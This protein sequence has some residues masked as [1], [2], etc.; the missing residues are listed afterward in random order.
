[1]PVIQQPL[2][3]VTAP[4]GKSLHLE[5][6]F[7][8]SPAPEVIWFRGNN[9]IL[10]NNMYKITV[11]ANFSSLDIREAFSD[12]SGSYTVLVRNVAGETSSVCQVVIEP[13][14]SS[15]GDE[16][17]QASADMEAQPP[18]FVQKLTPSKEVPEGTRVR[19]D[20]ILV[21]HP[22]PE[23]IWLKNEKPIKESPDIQ[24][25]FEGD[26]CTLIIREAI[27]NDS[28][29]FKCVA[30][31]PHGVAESVC[32]LHVE[33]VSEMSDASVT[34]PAAPRFTQ[35]LRDQKAKSGHRVCLQ[36]RV[37][38]HPLPE[39]QWFKDNH[40]LESSPDFQ[41]TA[42][43]DVHSLT[44]PEVFEEDTGNYAVRAVNRAGEAS[45]AARLT[46][47]PEEVPQDEMDRDK[48]QRREARPF[49]QRE[50][51][52]ASPPEMKR[53]FQDVYTRPG[54]CV[55]FEC[56][57]TGTPKPK[58]TWQF[59]GKPL[60]SQD[61]SVSMEG[62]THR[63]TIPEVFDEDAGRF[64]VHA[65]NPSGKTSC[66]ALL[67]VAP[68]LPLIPAPGPAVQRRQEVTM[69]LPDTPGQRSSWSES[70]M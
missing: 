15:P 21:G 26:R 16:V 48:V 24:L 31:N 10:P 56:E 67:S 68:P 5:V 22:E 6:R 9:R 13:F 35:P 30:Q 61:Y 27:P 54:E 34:E 25:L 20:C 58:V 11:T 2:Q 66:S 37:L 19:L 7:T 29:H 39:V 14:Y 43:A 45:C 53:R 40:P 59:N 65:E 38:G 8:G 28:G 57:V 70:E 36:C 12:D 41:I 3:D 46:V 4:E 60:V 33:P 63:L 62:N 23:V 18:Q 51:P 17:S 50:Q 69:E 44:I 32:K 42:F 55:V 52:K 49:F 47:D 64:S 1:M